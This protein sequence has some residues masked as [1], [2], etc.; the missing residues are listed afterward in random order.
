MVATEIICRADLEAG[1]LVILPVDGLPSVTYAVVLP[2]GP[3]RPAV[4]QFADWLATI[5]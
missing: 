3:R 1:R 2:K 4:A 5:F